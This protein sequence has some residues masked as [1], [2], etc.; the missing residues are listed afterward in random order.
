VEIP[1]VIAFE[2]A[3]HSYMDASCPELLATVR[4]E[5]T[6]SDETGAALNAALEDFKA[7]VPY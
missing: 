6:I 7:S 5:K 3:L 2:N 1:R 4:D